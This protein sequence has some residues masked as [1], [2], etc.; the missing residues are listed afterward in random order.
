MSPVKLTAK[1]VLF[2][3]HI[4]DNPADG[5][6]K[7]L[8][9]ESIELFDVDIDDNSCG[10]YCVENDRR[11]IYVN[12]NMTIGRRYF[13][14]A[15]ELGHH[16]LDHKLD[17]YCSIYRNLATATHQKEPQEVEANYFAACF[18]M[19]YD[20]VMPLFNAAVS[21]HGRQKDTALNPRISN[22]GAITQEIVSQM[23]NKLKVSQEAAFYRLK[24]LKL[25]V[26]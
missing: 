2:D 25:L 13:T 15:H 18:L 19:P 8:K 23:E 1:Q 11:K 4:S 16:F 10:M 9:G 22:Y 17:G 21:S 3:Y 12:Q 24:N 6:N 20:L 26:S 14:I 5:I 7:I